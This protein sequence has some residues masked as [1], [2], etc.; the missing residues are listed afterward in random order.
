[1]LLTTPPAKTTREDSWSLS[2]AI[3]PAGTVIRA[4]YAWKYDP[5][6]AY[7]AWALELLYVTNW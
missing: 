1:M 6:K 3:K 4:S 7:I 5:W 2:A